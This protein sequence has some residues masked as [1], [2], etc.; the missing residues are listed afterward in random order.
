MNLC[1]FILGI[2]MCIGDILAQKFIDDKPLTEID[3]VRTGRFVLVGVALLVRGYIL[4][5]QIPKSLPM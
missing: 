2:A 4:F 3:W 1:D 5:D